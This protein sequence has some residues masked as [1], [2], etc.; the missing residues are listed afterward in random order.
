MLKGTII[1][2]RDIIKTID[3][4]LNNLE[5]NISSKGFG[6]IRLIHNWLCDNNLEVLLYGWDIGSPSSVNRHELPEPLENKLLYGDI[7]VLL[8]E[9]NI[10]I[11]FSKEDYMIF[12]EEMFGG[13]DLCDSNDDTDL[14][15]DD[16]DYNDDFL[17]RD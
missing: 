4:D 2:K 9:N 11:N 16:Y 1:K 13:F 5:N 15:D 6:K 12:Y 14:E 10:F 8:K 7:I 3:I 17:V